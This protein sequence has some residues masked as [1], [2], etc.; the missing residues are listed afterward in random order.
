MEGLAA[1]RVVIVDDHP[2]VIRGVMDLLAGSPGFVVAASATSP[3][4]AIEVIRTQRPDLVT[5]D[6][7]L[8]EELAS[9]WVQ[10]L[11]AVSPATR[12]VLLTAFDDR[13][14]IDACLDG[15]ASGAI[16]KDASGLDLVAALERVMLGEIFIDPRLSSRDLVSQRHSEY[17]A[18]GYSALS[19][20]EYQ[21]LRLL[22]RGMNTREMAT[23]LSL[24]PN[25][26]RSYTQTVL[27]KLQSKN[28]VMAVAKARQLHLI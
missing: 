20:R 17:L 24:M 10:R 6:I 5:L 4:E 3:Q 15:G 12:I 18:G 26:V 1:R 28:R 23:H 11:L 27:G 7:R 22:A 21:V 9:E 8:G 25:T 19:K 16:L 13:E 2:I 14:L